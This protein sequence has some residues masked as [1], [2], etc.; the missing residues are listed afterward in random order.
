[1][2][3]K[4]LEFVQERIRTYT[5]S[6][7]HNKNT[8]GRL[9]LRPGGRF[10]RH[11]LGRRLSLLRRHESLPPSSI[12]APAPKIPNSPAPSAGSSAHRNQVDRREET[13]HPPTSH[14]AQI[15]R[16]HWSCDRR[17]ALSPI[18]GSSNIW[19]CSRQTSQRPG[20]AMA[21][22]V[23]KGHP[24]THFH[25][26][27]SPA[28]SAL[29]LCSYSCYQ[30]S[31]LWASSKWIT[32]RSDSDQKVRDDMLLNLRYSLGT[33]SLEDKLRLGFGGGF[34]RAVVNQHPPVHH[35]GWMICDQETVFCWVP[36]P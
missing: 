33:R 1:M 9:I 24:S 13:R 27:V 21:V 10:L 19:C 36:V 4:R 31:L 23:E 11:F 25:L 6:G 15:P 35:Q 17:E 22:N 16:S 14:Q 29:V 7:T 28:V 12:F 5:A 18:A 3:T 2:Y 34:S 30:L 32:T 20:T 8:L 26:S